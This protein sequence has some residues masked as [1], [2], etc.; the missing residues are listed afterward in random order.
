VEHNGGLDAFLL[1]AK[2]EQ[3]SPAVQK[4]KREIVKAKA[5]ATAAA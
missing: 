1:K 5:T 4:M 2:D 3:L